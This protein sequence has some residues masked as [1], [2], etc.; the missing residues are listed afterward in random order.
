MRSPAG[1]A[2]EIGRIENDF[3]EDEVEEVVSHDP[4]EDN[5][6]LEQ[7]KVKKH[8]TPQKETAPPPI[9]P[10]GG[11]GKIKKNLEEMSLADYY[12]ARGYTRDGFK[13]SRIIQ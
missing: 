2:R 10:L 5:E 6:M 4:T 12:E 9:K 1:V 3:L 8:K 11:K 13:K 7:G